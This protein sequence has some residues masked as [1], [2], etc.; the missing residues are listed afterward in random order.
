MMRFWAY[1]H[2]DSKMCRISGGL[3][4]KYERDESRIDLQQLGEWD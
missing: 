2:F 4:V 1:L 3:G